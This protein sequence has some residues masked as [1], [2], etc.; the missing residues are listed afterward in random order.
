MKLALICSEKLPSPAIRGGAIQTMIDGVVPF[1]RRRHEV[2][3]FSIT[4]PDLPERE[5]RDGVRYIRV[6]AQRYV[7]NV[8]QEL[9]HHSFDV[10]HVLNRPRAVLSYKKAAPDSR[11]VVSLH[12][13]MFSPAKL[14]IA[15]GRA[16]IEAVSAIATVSDYIGRT[17]LAWYPAA[18]DKLRTVYSGV[19]LKQFV[20]AWKPEAA[21]IRDA[22][23]KRYGVTG[24]KVILYIGRLS[25]KKGPHVLIEAMRHVL[26]RHPDAALVIVGGKWFSDDGVNRYIRL[27]HRLAAPYGD[28]IV[29]TKFVPPKEIPHHFLLG[30][31][32]VC[33]SQWQEPLAR[34]HYEA[35]AAGIPLITTKRGGNPEV[36]THGENGL[37]VEDYANPRA[38]AEAI[39]YL[40]SHPKEAQRMAKAGHA[41][42]KERFQFR[43][44][45]ER[46]EAFYSEA[47]GQP[48]E[49]SL[50]AAEAPTTPSEA[51]GQPP[52]A[53][54]SVAEASA[55]SSTPLPPQQGSDAPETPA[56]PSTPLPP[57]RGSDAPDTPAASTPAAPP[58]PPATPAPQ[59]V[60]PAN[61]ASVPLVRRPAARGGRPPS[62]P[63]TASAP[64]TARRGAPPKRLQRKG[65]NP[66]RERPRTDR[67][68]NGSRRP[69]RP[70]A[71]PPSRVRRPSAVGQRK[72]SGVGNPLQSRR[73]RP[74]KNAAPRR[75]AALSQH[76][77]PPL[78]ARRSNPP[79]HHP[80]GHRRRLR[81]R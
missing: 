25:F 7:E 73:V 38:F 27:L 66:P 6:P 14:P 75:T 65:G 74:Q 40:L 52:E 47:C 29:F 80:N 41:L 33:S 58:S 81:P 26:P 8:A 30:D 12:N 63:R 17:V 44:V 21:P 34:V 79:G 4:D 72:K 1:L 46:L 43:H 3:I 23:R 49:A 60:S 51:K 31:V 56:A 36:V 53:P 67:P 76:R 59:V 69:Q 70:R 22:L 15:L 48:R 55:A 37:L 2:T 50:P 28:R 68:A 20:P 71:V 61:P 19:D 32:F 11:F 35:M 64:R 62:R 45:A 24:K 18:R 39:D 9:R 78:A 54:P 16:V 77:R 13:E 57:K 42:V 10:I 5:E